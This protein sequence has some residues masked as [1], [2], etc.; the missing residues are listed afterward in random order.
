MPGWSEKKKNRKKKIKGKRKAFL[1]KGSN[2][3]NRK[4][5][6]YSLD[7]HVCAFVFL[8]MA[9]TVLRQTMCLPCKIF[10]LFGVHLF[11]HFHL[12]FHPET[13][14]HQSSSAWMCMCLHE[15]NGSTWQSCFS[16]RSLRSVVV[17]DASLTLI[18]L[19]PWPRWGYHYFDAFFS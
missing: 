18:A 1:W 10:F 4:V 19:V 15:R 13:Q 3:L 2:D 9:F 6:Y 11:K 17:A 14:S 7:L 8:V 5:N 12:L 16:S